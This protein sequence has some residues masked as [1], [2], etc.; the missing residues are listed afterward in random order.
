MTKLPCK[1]F[2]ENYDLHFYNKL[3]FKDTGRF[4][5]FQP[6]I[7]H[8]FDMDIPEDSDDSVLT[9]LKDS[10]TKNLVNTCGHCVD[11]NK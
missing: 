3:L 9:M 4:T 10:L 11:I 2:S 6:Q 8:Y 1:D 5:M 7:E